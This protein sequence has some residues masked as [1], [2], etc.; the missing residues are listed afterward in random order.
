VMVRTASLVSEKN[1]QPAGTKDAPAAA[2]TI[3]PVIH[4]RSSFDATSV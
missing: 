1:I 2:N 3:G 4:H